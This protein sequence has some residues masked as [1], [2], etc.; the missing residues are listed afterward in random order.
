MS[1]T[2]AKQIE[3][4]HLKRDEMKQ[5][6]AEWIER[7]NELKEWR[8][9]RDQLEIIDLDERRQSLD[10]KLGRSQQLHINHLNRIST[11]AKLKNDKYL[12]KTLTFRKYQ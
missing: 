11:E 1:L 5:R 4:D 8:E 9:E 2:V 7:N 3:L 10:D 6:E 12:K